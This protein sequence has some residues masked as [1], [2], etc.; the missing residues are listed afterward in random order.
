MEMSGQAVKISS[1]PSVRRSAWFRKNAGLRCLSKKL[2]TVER[3]VGYDK[4]LCVRLMSRTLL[5]AHLHPND[6]YLHLFLL[7][8]VTNF[9]EGSLK[10]LARRTI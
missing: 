6:N 5:Q 10:A 8:Q 1:M 2:S 4:I 3:K 7:S 9:F